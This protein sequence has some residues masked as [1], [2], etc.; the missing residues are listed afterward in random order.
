MVGRSDP[1][2]GVPAGNPVHVSDFVATIYHGLGIAADLEL[3]DRLNRP[4][5]L[6]PEGD[7]IRDVFS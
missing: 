5:P 3:R 7:P 1:T 2:G 6:V 4:L